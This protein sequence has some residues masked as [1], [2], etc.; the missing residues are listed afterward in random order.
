MIGKECY[1]EEVWI[2]GSILLG[3]I[4]PERSRH[5]PRRS[6]SSLCISLDRPWTVLFSE[7]EQL[8]R[9]NILESCGQPSCCR[10]TGVAQVPAKLRGEAKLQDRF[11][12]QFVAGTQANHSSVSWLAKPFSD[13][14]LG[15]DPLNHLWQVIEPA[16]FS[17]APQAGA[18]EKCA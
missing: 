9:C 11:R 1:H 10:S 4:P 12:A 6:A 2:M 17:G 8:E 16:A 15:S 13:P 5:C 18:P 3:S 14:A 7:S